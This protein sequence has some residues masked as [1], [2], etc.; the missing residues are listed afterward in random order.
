MPRV[1]TPRRRAGLRGLSLHYVRYRRPG[2]DA[3]W[4]LNLKS[5]SKQREP[6]QQFWCATIY[7]RCA[8]PLHLTFDKALIALHALHVR[9]WS[10]LQSCA[11]LYQCF[12][13]RPSHID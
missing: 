12:L 7:N 2:G 8:M 9:R 1:G 6:S 11:P 10:E 13:M 5:T 3:A 4:G